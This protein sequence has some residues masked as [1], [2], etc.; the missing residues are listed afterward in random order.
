MIGVIFNPTAHGDRA[1]VFRKWLAGLGGGAKL[2]QTTEPGSATE[3]ARCAIEEGC[4]T[5]VA[6]GGDGTVNEVLNG[7]VAAHEGP[8]RARLAVLPLGTVNVFAKELGLPLKTSAAWNVILAGHERRIDLPWVDWGGSHSR[9]RRYFVQMAG[10]G[11]D[12]RALGRVDL[13]LKRQTG[14]GAYLWA[15]LLSLKSPRPQVTVEA[16]GRRVTGEFVGIGNGRF[17]GGRFP[18]FPGAQLDN[19]HLEVTVAPRMNPLTLLRLL[20]A[21]WNDRLMDCASAVCFRATEGSMAAEDGTPWHVEGELGGSLP[22]TFSLLPRGLRV[23]VPAS[24]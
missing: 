1:E 8:A 3:L 21:L 15:G 5:L 10:A 6:A 20:T 14:V 11:L 7:L 9:Q 19:G 22:A 4:T 13:N 17:Y 24:G 12:S 16:A 2:F 23:V 18:V